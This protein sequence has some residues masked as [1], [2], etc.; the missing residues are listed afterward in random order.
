MLHHILTFLK[1]ELIISGFCLLKFVDTVKLRPTKIMFFDKKAFHNLYKY[2]NVMKCTAS[3]CISLC[4]NVRFVPETAFIWCTLSVVKICIIKYKFLTSV[5]NPFLDT[6]AKSTI[7]SLH[8]NY[9]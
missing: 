4:V 8:I 1:I 3:K 5:I 6:K 2:Q 9:P 7:N